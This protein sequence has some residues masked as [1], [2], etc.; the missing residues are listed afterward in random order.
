MEQNRILE[1]LE[2]EIL[3]D[4]AG[5]AVYTIESETMRESLDNL[6]EMIE[7]REKILNGE[8]ERQLKLEAASEKKKSEA[9]DRWIKIGLG[10]L[11]VF[12]TIVAVT[13]P[14]TIKA[15]M[16]DRGL[17][18]EMGKGEVYKSIWTKALVNSVGKLDK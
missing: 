6:N 9:K 13:I 3:A 5:L 10:V 14:V 11:E 7:M 15:K 18:Y 1:L 16:M 8:V 12:G 17:D 2:E 4:Q